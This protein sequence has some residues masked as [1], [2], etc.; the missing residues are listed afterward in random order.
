MRNKKKQFFSAI[1]T[2]AMSCILILN[3]ALP[4]MAAGSESMVD[5]IY[6]IS[7]NLLKSTSD[8]LSMADQALLGIELVK[9]EGEITAFLEMGPLMGT[10]LLKFEYEDGSGNYREADVSATDGDGNIT[11][12]SFPVSYGTGTINASFSF[13]AIG[14]PMTQQAR[15]ALDWS[16][17]NLID[18]SENE[19]EDNESEG[20]ESED[21]E[22]EGNES[23]GS[24]SEDNES[25][26]NNGNEPET[27]YELEEGI[28]D[29]TAQFWHAVNDELSSANGTIES[30]QLDVD[31]EGN[32]RVILTLQ[33]ARG[34][35]FY[36]FQYVVEDGNYADVQIE[37]GE[38]NAPDKISFT[39]EKNVEL[40]FMKATYPNP[41]MGPHTVDMRLYLDLEHA[42][43]N[44]E[45]ENGNESEENNIKDGKY[46]IDAKILN[47]ATEELSMGDSA[48]ESAY[49]IVKDGDLTLNMNMKD[50]QGVYLEK[51]E[52]E[53]TAARAAVYAQA[54]EEAKDSNGNI[55]RFSI[56]IEYDSSPINVKFTF[57]M[58]TVMTQ[59]ARLALD[60]D[61]FE[62]L[63][64]DIPDE[65]DDNN[66]SD[67]DN[68][69][70]DNNDN[71]NN[72]ND[73]D[74]NN[75][76]DTNNDTDNDTTGTLNKDQLKDGIYEVQ[77]DLWNA[78]S[79]KASMAST[80]VVKK[81][82][83]S[84]ENGN[85]KMYLYTQQMTLGTISA[86]LQ[87][88][89]TE[90]ASGGYSQASI[91]S[92]DGSGNP[93]SFAFDMPHTGEYIKVKVNPKVEIMGNDYI[94]ARLK[95]AW[96]TLSKVSDDTSLTDT[97]DDSGVKSSGSGSTTKK[98]AVK[99]GDETNLMAISSVVVI[100]AAM[101]ICV[102]KMKMVR[103]VAA[104][105][106]KTTK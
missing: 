104:K 99:T 24:E 13:E 39:L 36:N 12:F 53:S 9:E 59:P 87:E 11:G 2:F 15:L 60:W 57:N 19:S 4:V 97:P 17:L 33:P 26:E 63:S 42:V 55:T 44:T 8:D 67:N 91:N 7:G 30:A 77:V 48:L 35:S 85:Y 70:N 18:A 68:N 75:G 6:S 22:S 69:D 101:L 76:S 81:A 20:N 46:S 49:I 34:L 105:D 92:K 61:T 27:I 79:D 5:G 94:D 16:S 74:N 51:F 56:P 93:T 38:A 84:V 41:V 90:N 58:G 52:Y 86:Y 43:L 80:S 31:Q 64:T 54:K 65:E 72:N 40:T 37:E 100:S 25:E 96:S 106:E 83:I 66:N 1:M 10:Y 103:K 95:L 102:A 98:S 28:Y 82:R 29:V 50:I 71:D 73:N 62:L 47:A 89:Q 21:N 32:I 3:S 14:R 23:E 88:M 45:S 78:T